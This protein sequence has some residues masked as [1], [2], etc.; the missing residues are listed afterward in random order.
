MSL[1]L[2]PPL[3]L[4]PFP[5]GILAQSALWT[6]WH[7]D[8]KTLS[9]L[10]QVPKLKF[11]IIFYPHPSDC[12]N[13]FFFRFFSSFTINFYSKKKCITSNWHVSSITCH[14][15]KISYL[16]FLQIRFKKHYLHLITCFRG[17]LSYTTI[18]CWV[19]I[20][21]GISMVL[22]CKFNDFERLEQANNKNK[23]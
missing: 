4:L 18:G 21:G 8:F 7:F 6:L 17:S 5:T 2:P 15:P 19:S 23:I 14:L 22:F 1:S 3:P 10:V 11:L 20:A 12:T 9:Q 16:G 13:Y